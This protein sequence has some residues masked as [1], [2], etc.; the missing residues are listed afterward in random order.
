MKSSH[1]DGEEASGPVTLRSL[2]AVATAG[3]GVP[4]T[5]WLCLHPGHLLKDHPLVVLTPLTLALGGHL[6]LAVVIPD[7]YI[8]PLSRET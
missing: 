5:L 8:M 3:G 2:P 1:L 7:S 6:D 4:S